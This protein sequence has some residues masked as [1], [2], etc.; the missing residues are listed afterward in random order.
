MKV[1]MISDVFFPRV[2]GVSTSI[3]TF[4]RGLMGEGVS[5]KVVAPEYPGA[6]PDSNVVRV[7]SRRVPLDPEDRFMHWAQLQA[8]A[9][10]LG[11]EGVDLIHV[12][13]PFAAH[14]GGVKLARQLGV[15]VVAT[16]HTFF[17]EYLYHYLP[18]VPKE[19][20]RGLARRF[21]RNQCNDLDAVIVPSSAMAE[22]L[23]QYGV[24]R[25]LHVIPTGIPAGQFA[26]GDRQRF[27]QQW[28]IPA[29]QPVALYVGRVAH[30]K[31]IELLLR[32]TRLALAMV[33][34]LLLVITGEGPALAS[35]QK[36]AQTL[37]LGDHV[38]FLGYLD[39]TEALPD[40]YAGADVFTFA[41]R[42]ETQGLVLLEAMAA[43]LPVLGLSA[44]GTRDI[45]EPRRGCVVAQDDPVE[46]AQ[47]LAEILANGAE[48]QRLSAAAKSFCHEWSDEA[49]ARKM[50]NLYRTLAGGERS[51]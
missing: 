11:Q 36:T 46:F 21:S 12:Q 33:P 3:E 6:L 15:P 2:N 18:V 5:V 49:C 44:M 35:L 29:Q 4:R 30:E 51:R 28:N 40:A 39:R 7:P 26:L 17:E 47:K 8:V 16:Y 25:P 38:R 37:G 31:N 48:R 34:D 9:T 14:Y 41:S 42:T 43:G 24:N 45:L 32:A 27:R 1:L 50:A 19:W 22:R 13:T 20:M 10:T 23:Q